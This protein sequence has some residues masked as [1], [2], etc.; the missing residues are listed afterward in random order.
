MICTLLLLPHFSQSDFFRFKIYCETVHHFYTPYVFLDGGPSHHDASNITA[1][2]G[3]A[4]IWDPNV[5]VLNRVTI[6]ISFYKRFY[7]HMLAAKYG[8]QNYK[9]VIQLSTFHVS[10]NCNLSYYGAI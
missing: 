6:G 5:L 8:E 9:L 1:Q 3:N 2:L 4:Y 10:L 7:I